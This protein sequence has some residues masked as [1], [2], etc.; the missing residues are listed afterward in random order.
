MKKVLKRLHTPP[1]EIDNSTPIVCEE[2]LKIIHKARNTNSD[3]ML[4]LPQVKAKISLA[5]STIWKLAHEG[6]LPAPVPLGPRAVAWREADLQAW[7]EARIYASR[8]KRS[9]DMKAF[10]A[11][12]TVK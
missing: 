5:A 7:I 2:V 9:I 8:S 4:R 11:L 10:V 6:S 3:H 12:L 1:S